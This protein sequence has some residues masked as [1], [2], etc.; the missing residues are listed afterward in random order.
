MARSSKKKVISVEN[1]STVNA[2]LTPG[3]YHV[4]V[5][6]VVAHKVNVSGLMWVFEVVDGDSTGAKTR[7]HFTSVEGP[8]RYR[9]KNLLKALDYDMPGSDFDLDLEEVIDAELFIEVI[10]KE[11]TRDDGTMAMG[12]EIAGYLSEKEAAALDDAPKAKPAKAAEPEEDE[13]EEEEEEPKRKAKKAKPAEDEIP[14]EEDEEEEKPAPK[15]KGKK[16]KKPA[17][18][19]DMIN[20]M[21]TEELEAF[22]EEHELDVEISKFRTL[23]KQRAAVIKAAGDLIE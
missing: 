2:R 11:W 21:D 9:L 22:V 13:E 20:E 19:E 5:Q 15:S 14:F 8:G 6:D 12:T 17:I 3:I 10:E 4:K 1:L 16:A 23:S 18:T 7:P